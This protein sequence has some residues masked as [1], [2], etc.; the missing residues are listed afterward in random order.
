MYADVSK[1]LG[2]AACIL[3]VG[4]PPGISLALAESVLASVSSR[5]QAFN[6]VREGEAAFVPKSGGVRLPARSSSLRK[7]EAAEA[8]NSRAGSERVASSGSA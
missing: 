1:R 8:A 6:G 3:S 4:M 7:R 5:A 2:Q